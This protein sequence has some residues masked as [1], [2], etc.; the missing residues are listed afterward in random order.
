MTDKKSNESRRKLLKSIAV[1]SGAIMSGKSLP[2]NWT[3]PVV[4][5]VMLPAHAQTSEIVV[6]P[7]PIT[8]ISVQQDPGCSLNSTIY[9]RVEIDD[10]L[11]PTGPYPFTIEGPV[12]DPGDPIFSITN[13][14]RI[15]VTQNSN[16][17]V[18]VGIRIEGEISASGTN[19]PCNAPVSD[20]T[21][22]YADAE[23]VPNSTTRRFLHT[24]VRDNVGGVPSM[25]INNFSV[26]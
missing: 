9:Y 5:T 1:G 2:E 6:N 25:T 22:F 17:G 7:P 19:N 11:S 3:R 21:P 20:T 23:G 10:S 14:I 4:N 24:F 12:P 13:F 8:S 18:G 16:P 26:T 15:I